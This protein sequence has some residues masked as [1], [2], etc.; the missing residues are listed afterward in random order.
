MTA[1]LHSASVT[2]WATLLSGDRK[3]LLWTSPFAHLHHGLS[4]HSFIHFQDDILYLLIRHAEGAQ[5]DS[6]HVQR[7]T[8]INLWAT[9]TS[10]QKPTSTGFTPDFSRPWVSKVWPGGHIW[11][12][13]THQPAE[14]LW[15]MKPN[16]P[17]VKACRG[18]FR[19]VM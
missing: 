10:S 17:K 6:C 19:V 16:L 3:K 5:K 13:E 8:Q 4:Q 9:K 1:R 7:E 14:I 15:P 2:S 18:T 11:P 12:T